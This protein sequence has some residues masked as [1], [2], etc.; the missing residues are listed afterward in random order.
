M[1]TSIMCI[2]LDCSETI[3]LVV[4]TGIYYIYSSTVQVPFSY[5]QHVVVFSFH[6]TLYYYPAA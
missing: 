4:N 2:S 3:L 5:I 1:K 6:D